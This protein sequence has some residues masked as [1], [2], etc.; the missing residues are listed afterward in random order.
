MKLF[1]EFPSVNKADWLA[2]VEKDLKGKPIENLNWKVGEGLEF[3]PFS[4]Q[5]DLK[6][7]Y[8]PIENGQDSNQWEIGVPIFVTSYKKANKE[9]LAALNNGA[10]ALCFYLKKTPTKTE[11][12]QLLNNIQHEWISTH[13]IVAQKAWSQL[14]KNFI[15]ILKSKGQKTKNVR[16]SFS[17][18]GNQIKK[19]KTFRD[20]IKQLPQAKLLTIN[21][22]PFFNGKEN[23]IEELRSIC[24]ALEKLLNQFKS[25]KL[26]IAKYSKTIQI[27]IDLSD[28]YFLNIAKIR[29]IKLLWQKILTD[30]KVKETAFPTIEIQLTKSSQITDENFN[31]IKAGAQAM[32]AVIGGANRLCIHPSDAFQKKKSSSFNQRIALNMQH[33][34]QMESYIDRVVDPSAGSYYIEHLTKVLASKTWDLLKQ[35][36]FKRNKKKGK[37]TKATWMTPEDI[38]IA[39]TYTANTIKD[40]EHLN[41]VAGLAP[42][43]RGPYSSMYAG[44]P[45]T[46]RQYA[47][48]STAKESNAFYRRNL[49]QGQKGLSVAFDLA[50]HRGYDSDHPRVTGDVGMAGVAIDTVEDMKGRAGCG[51]I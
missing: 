51:S 36:K 29:A 21:A 7:P 28:S 20:I 49:A 18:E 47:G 9:A 1:K 13:F 10:N 2:K 5:E 40:I 46:I 37:S 23:I 19:A 11:L 48:F 24:K 17:F 35:N 22:I 44:R 30:W 25:H 43:L 16:C 15:S 31:K 41:F 26:D 32:A 4:H 34:M 42:N 45:W 6:F 3:S 12:T 33:L 38:S 14:V 50:T 8:G 39:P 27:S